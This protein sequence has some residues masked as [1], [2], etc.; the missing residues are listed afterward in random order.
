MKKIA[1]A[2][3]AVLMCAASA[4]ADLSG[5]TMNVNITHD[6]F[7]VLSAVSGTH[8]YGAPT[9]LTAFG[10]GDVLLTSPAAAPLMDNA[11]N[12]DFTN[13]AY[14]AFVAPFPAI[15]TIKITNIAEPFDLS[16]VKILVNGLN[17]ATGVANFGN[18]FQASW[19]AP[20]VFNGNPIQ[21]NLTVAWNSIVPAPGA[22]ALLGL[23]GLVGRRGRARAN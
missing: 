9:T 20:L 4:L 3:F 12:V 21:P 15:G 6:Q 11:M 2:V 10:W 23:A 1:T 14:S 22:L 13:F 19:S 7:T 5:T 16:S 18:G 17:I 8:T